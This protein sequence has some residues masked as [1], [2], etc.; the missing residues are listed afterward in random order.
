MVEPGGAVALSCV[1]KGRLP[2]AYDT[3]VVVASGGNVDAPAFAAALNRA[4][5]L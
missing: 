5:P 4:R 2:R 1:L 3:V